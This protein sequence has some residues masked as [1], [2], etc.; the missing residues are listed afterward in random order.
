MNC[1][2]VKQH[3]SQIYIRKGQHPFQY[4]CLNNAWMNATFE[5]CVPN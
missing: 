2:D 4:H 5:V 1:E 3:F